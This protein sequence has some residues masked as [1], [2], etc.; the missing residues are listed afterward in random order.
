MQEVL[1]PE[2]KDE[3]DSPDFDVGDQQSAVQKRTDLK[4]AYEKRALELTNEQRDENMAFYERIQRR[5]DR[6][7]R[8]YEWLAS[9]QQELDEWAKVWARKANANQWVTASGEIRRDDWYYGAN[10]NAGGPVSRTIGGQ[11]FLFSSEPVANVESDE[12]NVIST[13]LTPYDIIDQNGVLKNPTT[14]RLRGTIVEPP[15]PTQE[16]PVQGLI[17][18]LENGG[19]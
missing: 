9:Q 15:A 3:L 13:N 5:E 16:A 11:K 18:T 6:R 8:Y 10:F 2:K 4:T 17:Q 1:L 14:E 19:M 12:L 7:K